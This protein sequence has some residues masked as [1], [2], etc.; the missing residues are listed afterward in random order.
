MIRPRLGLRPKEIE[1]IIENKFNK[2][3]DLLI[4]IN[5]PEVAEIIEVLKQ[6]IIEVVEENNREIESEFYDAVEKFLVE[7]FKE[8]SRR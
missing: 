7:K 3:A 6:V 2:N 1:E 8:A 5:D 4:G